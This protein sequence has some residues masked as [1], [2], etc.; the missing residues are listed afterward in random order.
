MPE[1]PF[2]GCFDPLMALQCIL[3]LANQG[4][5]LLGSCC[6]PCSF[7]NFSIPRPP[8]LT[9][10]L[11]GGLI[12]VLNGSWGSEVLRAISTFENW[13]ESTLGLSPV[14]WDPSIMISALCGP[15]WW[16]G[17]SWEPPQLFLLCCGDNQHGFLMFITSCII[18]VCFGCISQK[19]FVTEKLHK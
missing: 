5:Y 17:G 4:S 15:F 7:F 1:F 16:V 10:F 19:K 8:L 9:I 3:L 12:V 2:P 18:V 11:L 6:K 14:F 13:W